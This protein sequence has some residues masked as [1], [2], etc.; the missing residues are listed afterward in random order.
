M[1]ASLVTSLP[2]FKMKRTS[3]TTDPPAQTFN[4]TELPQTKDPA[5]GRQASC[6]TAHRQAVL[7]S[8]PESTVYFNPGAGRP[9]NQKHN[10]FLAEVFCRVSARSIPRPNIYLEVVH[11]LFAFR[12]PCRRSTAPSAPFPS[13]PSRP[14][15]AFQFRPTQVH[16]KLAWSFRRP[17]P[18]FPLPGTRT[19]FKFQVRPTPF[20]PL[21]FVL[22][23]LH[24]AALHN[25]LNLDPREQTLFPRQR[26]QTSTSTQPT[27]T[28][29]TARHA[30]PCPRA[31]QHYKTCLLAIA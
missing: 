15:L 27:Y 1:L 4:A 6:P 30:T 2:A 31:I 16:Q 9:S 13:H 19:H 12:P 26:Q 28:L 14:P 5:R 22:F 8:V 11:S 25:H 24:R 17:T 18:S 29:V 21:P 3:T 20:L 7:S 23:H 10:N